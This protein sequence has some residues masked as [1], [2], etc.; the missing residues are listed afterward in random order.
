M[1]RKTDI[2][3]GIAVELSPLAFEVWQAMQAETLL[4]APVA[5][6]VVP[7]QAHHLVNL[8]RVV[9]SRAATVQEISS[10]ADELEASIEPNW[11]GAGS[12]PYAC[13]REAQP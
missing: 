1:T 9:A 7:R 2:L 3:L 6:C 5:P 4:S 12:R 11:S 8:L 13:S 10:I